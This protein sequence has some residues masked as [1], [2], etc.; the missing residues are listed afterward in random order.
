LA[1][2]VGF[3]VAYFAVRVV[4]GMITVELPPWM[5]IRIDNS[6]LLFLFGMSLLTGLLA[7]A[8]PALRASRRDVNRTLSD[9]SRGSSKDSRILQP[10]V[11]IEIAFAVVLLAGAALMV[12]SFLR[13]QRVDLGFRPDRLL[14]F[15]VGLSWR[16]YNLECARVFEQQVLRG[17]SSLPGVEAAVLSTSLPLT[18][19]EQSTQI[20]TDGQASERD[21]SRN[22]L[23]N[24]QQVS[25]NY[26]RVMGIPLLQGRYFSDFDHE[27][28][29]AVAIVSTHLA[30]R[31]WP[32]EEPLGKHILPADVMRP[33]T[34]TRLTVV[35]V[36]G[37]VKHESPAS[38]PG[39]DLYM[40][41]VQAGTQ[42]ANFAVRASL[43]AQA[44][45]KQALQ[46]VASV[47]R[48]EPVS[49]MMTMQQVIENTVWQRRL[50]GVVFVI[51]GG[52]ALLLATIGTYGVIAYSVTQRVK[53]IGI[54]SALGARPPDIIRMVVTDAGRF[55]L[56]GVAIGI[57]I[58]LGLGHFVSSLLFEIGATDPLT[59][60][61][62]VGVLTS[63]SA[64]ACLVPAWRAANVDPLKALREE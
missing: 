33:W 39:L 62:V 60:G 57:A 43:D 40:P 11:A 35:G 18:G 31:L 20:A 12:Q 63:V 7:G 59:L 24:F 51:L 13:L 10:L 14:T 56:P 25:A 49:E 1:G 26:H 45:A 58:A 54:R 38:E 44:L 48:E 9:G 19:H 6:V 27:K 55:I 28:S 61:G 37:D 15:E 41:F 2:S 36:V 5:D 21:Q 46:I 4:S 47:D 52:L 34:P 64:V 8:M 42:Y 29:Q 32:G 16:K 17:L 53:E 3:F 22:P 23:V 50:T 30:K